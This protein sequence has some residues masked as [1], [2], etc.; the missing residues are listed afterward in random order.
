MMEKE[1]RTVN[2]GG[3]GLGRR[4]EE[5][6]WAEESSEGGEEEVRV[7]LLPGRLLAWN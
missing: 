5:E 6:M 3:G 4:A 2:W 1:V 7:E